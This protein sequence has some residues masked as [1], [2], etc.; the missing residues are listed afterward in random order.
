MFGP[1]RLDPDTACVWRDDQAVTLKPNNY[2][3]LRYLVTHAGQLVTK[4]ALFK[5]IWSDVVVGDA[6]L[7]VCISEIRKA[8]G[9]TAKGS[10]FIAT[11]HRRGY[12]FV[13]PVT[14]GKASP[15]MPTAGDG[16]PP[17]PA[18]CR[19]RSPTQPSLRLLER[20]DVL[21][22]LQIALEGARAGAHHAVF[23]T[24]EPGIGKTVVVEA[25]LAGA[26]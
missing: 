20:D 15:L 10:Q 11:V 7:K 5:A 14:P 13:A 25:F 26:A 23:I 22:W 16:P 12:R 4:E 17:D 2:A 8:L 18:T 21:Q 3:V 24:G 6:V 9:D 19:H 1:F